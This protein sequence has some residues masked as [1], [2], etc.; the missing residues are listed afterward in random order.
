VVVVGGTYATAA[1]YDVLAHRLRSAGHDVSVFALP[2][3]GSGDIRSSASALGTFVDGVLARTGASDV[4]LV[5]HSQGG[6]VARQYIRFAGGLGRV[7]TSISLGTPH[8]GA[9]VANLTSSFPGCDAEEACRQ[10]A[11]G[12]AFLAGLN[13]GD[14]TFGDT[15][16]VNLVT[17]WDQVVTPALSGFMHDGATNVLVQQHCPLR[18]VGHLGLVVDG[19]VAT[20]ITSALTGGPVALDCL[21]L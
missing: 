7:D 16:Y 2:H 8:H 6:L 1:G 12:S 13:E 10:M 18:Y 14:E 20:G 4:D 5:G 11:I 19:T 17:A 3:G 9:A 15:R 21:A